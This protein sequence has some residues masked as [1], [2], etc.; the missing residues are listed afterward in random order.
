MKETRSPKD[1]HAVRRS[2]SADE[3]LRQDRWKHKPDM[4]TTGAV[5]IMEAMPPPLETNLHL[6]SPPNETDFTGALETPTPKL[7]T[8]LFPLLLPPGTPD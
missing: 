3:K 7:S 4:P 2:C 6:R 5:A 8:W 1:G